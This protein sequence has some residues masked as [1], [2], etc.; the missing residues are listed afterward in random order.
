MSR[1]GGRF[2]EQPTYAVCVDPLADSWADPPD[3]EVEIHAGQATLTTSALRVTLGRE[4]FRLDVHRSDGSPVIETAVDGGGQPWAYATL[5]D[6]FTFRRRCRA[7]DAIYG[8]GEKGGR[9]NRKGRDFTL[10]NTDVLDPTAASAFTDHY[11]DGDPRADRTSTEFD[12]YYANIPFFYHLRYPT[13]ET[14]G[15]FL[16][17]GYRSVFDFTAPQEYRVHVEGGQ[18]TEYVFAG[19]AIPDILTAYTGLTGRMAPPPLWSLGYHQCRWAIY[20]AD[21][22]EAIAVQHRDL[23]V[24]CDALWL[25]IEYMGRLSGLHLEQGVVP[26]PGADAVPAPRAGLSGH[27]HHRPGGEV[28]PG[29]PGFRRRG[30]GRRVLPYPGRGPVRRPSLAG[31]HPSSPTS[32]RPRADSGGETSTPRTWTPAWP[33]SGTT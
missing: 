30:R 8:L 31:Q 29:L 33:G 6:A 17:N 2:E 23:A 13:G 9:H 1:A 27:H 24:P 26:R 10:W 14:A 3:F 28:R 7:E 4:P 25:D 16:D 21:Q 12:P 32:R 19:P 5:N 20:T 18:W 11:P 15:S 22:V